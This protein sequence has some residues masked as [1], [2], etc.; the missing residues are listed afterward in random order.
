MRFPALK[1]HSRADIYGCSASPC[2]GSPGNDLYRFEKIM[3]CTFRKYRGLWVVGAVLNISFQP[4]TCI[5][6][7]SCQ[8]RPSLQR[9]G[10]AEAIC[11]DLSRKRDV[12]ANVSGAL[13]ALGVR[14]V[15]SCTPA[16]LLR[17]AAKAGGRRDRV[18]RDTVVWLAL[19]LC[20]PRSPR[21]SRYLVSLSDL[22]GCVEG[23]KGFL[24]NLG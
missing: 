7:T 18:K 24:T 15:A 20:S 14:F 16:A 9:A 21:Q 23:A 8:W 12:L 3:S 22:V 10:C 19:C 5:S 2:I 13:G 4:Q 11:R 17:S 1:L 6:H